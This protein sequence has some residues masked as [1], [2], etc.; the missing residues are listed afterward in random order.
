[1]CASW[2]AAHPCDCE[3][4]KNTCSC[5]SYAASNPCECDASYP[6][7]HPCE[8]PQ[9]KLS[10]ACPGWKAANPC[11]C[12]DTKYTCA[13]VDWKVTHP[14]DCEDTKNTCACLTYASAHPCE[15]DSTYP[16][17]HPCDCPLTKN[18]CTCPDYAAANPDKCF[19]WCPDVGTAY[20]YFS[21]QPVYQRQF[22]SANRAG[23]TLANKNCASKWGWWDTF[24][25]AELAAGQVYS[26]TLL[27]GAG[28]YN[29]DAATPVGS[30]TL[31]VSADGT[32]ALFGFQAS[33]DY[34]FG[35]IHVQ[36]NCALPTTCA[37]G[38][39]NNVFAW[40]WVLFGFFTIRILHFPCVGLEEG[41]N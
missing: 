8:C 17:T 10:C 38:Q 19:K 2:H 9:T 26:G 30:F 39:F 18:V 5:P 14:C 11:Q 23:K 34:Q 20:G 35:T 36:A 21:T 1:M 12:E 4:S 13:C 16:S 29:V 41:A 27:S 32:N 33:G 40:F 6:G 7:L 28:N 25:P 15:C 3:D 24:V 22:N 31:S 37:P